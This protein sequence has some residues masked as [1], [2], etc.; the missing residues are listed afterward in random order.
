MS[1]EQWQDIAEIRGWD[2]RAKNP[3]PH[4]NLV[5]WGKGMDLV[6]AVYSLTQ[7]FPDSELYGLRAQLRRAALF[8]AI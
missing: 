4:R 7:Q 5:A 8:R 6:S 2:M 1:S 3:K